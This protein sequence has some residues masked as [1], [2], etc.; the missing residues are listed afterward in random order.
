MVDNLH[1]LFIQFFA[2]SIGWELVGISS[3]SLINFYDL[4][5][6]SNLSS[7]QTIIVNKLGDVALL[8]A[9]ILTILNLRFIS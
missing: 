4:T 6:T 9:V 7:T 5:E 1:C 2:L 8:S 3:Y